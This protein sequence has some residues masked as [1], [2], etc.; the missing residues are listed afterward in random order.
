[1]CVCVCLIS[2]AMVRHK[3]AACGF[4]RPSG[5]FPKM[6]VFNIVSFNLLASDRAMR[7]EAPL[8]D[9]KSKSVWQSEETKSEF[10]WFRKCDD[11][12][13]G[14]RKRKKEISY[15]RNIQNMSSSYV[16][17]TVFS[18]RT[19]FTCENIK[20]TLHIRWAQLEE[21]AGANG[22]KRHIRHITPFDGPYMTKKI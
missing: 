3:G 14:K 22:C 2:L 7:R 1:M 21:K 17:I 20:E 9:W 19:L 5:P 18:L 6:C 16:A 13:H 10:N 4:G 12:Q 11:S 8:P 15:S